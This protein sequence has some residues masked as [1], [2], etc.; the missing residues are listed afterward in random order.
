MI[1]RT[2]SFVSTNEHTTLGYVGHLCKMLAIACGKHPCRVLVT[3]YVGHLCVLVGADVG[4]L[5]RV[6]GLRYVGH[7]YRV[8]LIGHGGHPCRVLVIGDVEHPC[9]VLGDA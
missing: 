1:S 8:L 5:R 7:P 3:A 2:R 9:S 6:L 4:H